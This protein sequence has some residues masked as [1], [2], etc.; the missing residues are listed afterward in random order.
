MRTATRLV[1]FAVVLGAIPLSAACIAMDLRVTEPTPTPEQVITGRVTLHLLDGS[2]SVYPHGVRLHDGSFVGPGLRYDLTLRNC[3]IAG[4]VPAD[5]VARIT[6]SYA[7]FNGGRTAL[8][9]GLAVGAAGAMV[10]L[11]AATWSSGW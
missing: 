5:S 3:G 10:A 11:L 4:S 9:N 2:T 8:V 6:R 7:T 1:T